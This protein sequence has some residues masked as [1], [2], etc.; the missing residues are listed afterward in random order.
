MTLRT[1]VI[2]SKIWLNS[3][4]HHTPHYLT[5]MSQG[6]VILGLTFYIPRGSPRV[7]LS[8]FEEGSSKNQELEDLES[9]GSSTL[10]A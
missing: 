2:H 9:S 10:V 5:H 6:E 7:S 3:V 4:S 8:A 1:V